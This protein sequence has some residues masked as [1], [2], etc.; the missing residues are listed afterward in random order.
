MNATAMEIHRAIQGGAC[1]APGRT[2][3]RHRFFKRVS[4]TVERGILVFA[5]LATLLGSYLTHHH[6]MREMLIS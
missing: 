4:H 2:P 3:A 6:L 5:I 1:D